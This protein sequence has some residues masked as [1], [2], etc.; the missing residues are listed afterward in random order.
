M[1]GIYWLLHTKSLNEKD[2]LTI[3]KHFKMGVIEV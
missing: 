1:C 3:H 2:E